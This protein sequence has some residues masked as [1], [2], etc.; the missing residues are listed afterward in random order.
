MNNHRELYNS[1]Q[2]S[3][4]VLGIDINE[5]SFIVAGKKLAAIDIVRIYQKENH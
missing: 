3:I 2:F 1:I 5:I 4:N